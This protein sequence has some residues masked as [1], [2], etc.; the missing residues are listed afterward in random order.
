ME[1]N[2]LRFD[3]NDGICYY[4]SLNT[5]NTLYISEEFISEKSIDKVGDEIRS[6]NT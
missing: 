3:H 6:I 1:A 4:A 2:T 5:A